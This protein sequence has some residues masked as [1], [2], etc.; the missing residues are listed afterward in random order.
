MQ[1][2]SS[3]FEV[4]MYIY[5]C[6]LVCEELSNGG[7]GVARGNVFQETLLGAGFKTGNFVDENIGGR[8][9][10]VERFLVLKPS[11]ITIQRK[12]NENKRRNQK[13]RRNAFFFSFYFFI[14]CRKLKTKWLRNAFFLPSFYF[15]TCYRIFSLIGWLVGWLVGWLALGNNNNRLQKHF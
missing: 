6:F 3:Y 12:P 11:S 7:V 15:L 14:F 10:S 2:I 9:A 8:G 1:K 5:I 4:Y 13:W